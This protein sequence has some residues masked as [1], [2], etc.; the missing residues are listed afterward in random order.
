MKKTWTII[1][2]VLFALACA[3][4]VRPKGLYQGKFDTAGGEK[5][6]MRALKKN[7]TNVFYFISPECPLC[8]NYA[9]DI[10]DIQEEYGNDSTAFIGVVSGSDYTHQDV[11]DYLAEYDLDLTVIMDPNFRLVQYFKATITPEVFVVNNK[12]KVQY[13]GKIDNWAVS[14]GQHRQVVTEFYLKDALADIGSGV[15]VR[16]DQTEPVGCFIE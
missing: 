8:V 5:F 6:S 1:L 9:K 11:L 2:I 15:P 12:S 3:R 4:A 14:L 16:L 7:Y 10:K 13:T